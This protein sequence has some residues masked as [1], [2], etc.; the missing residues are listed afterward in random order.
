M[1]KT[2]LHE[3]NWIEDLLPEGCIKKHMFGGFAYYFEN[4]LVLCLF[5]DAKTKSY[6]NLK[7]DFAIWNG[8]LFPCDRE[9]HDAIFKKY[10]FLINHPVLPKWLYLPQ[11]S[12]DFESQVEIILKEIR[13]RSPLFGTV[14]KTKKKSSKKQIAVKKAR[15]NTKKPRIFL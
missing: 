14:P 2:Q 6:K 3:L 8:C 9:N 7:F 5:E 4:K 12:E 11:Q 10:P 13:R 15:I 1:A